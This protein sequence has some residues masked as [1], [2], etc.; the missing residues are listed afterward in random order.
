MFYDFYQ[1]PDHFSSRTSAVSVFSPEINHG[2]PWQMFGKTVG[3]SLIKYNFWGDQN[4]RHNYPP[5]PVLDPLVGTLF[6]LGLVYVIYQTVKLLG[7]RFREG[8]RDERLIRNWLLLSAFFVMLMPEFLTEEG[9]PH[10]LRAIGTQTPVFLL[11]TLPLIR[12]VDR[13]KNGFVGTRIAFLSLV[14]VVLFVSGFFNLTKYF[15]FFC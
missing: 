10:A 7:E 14:V 15:V 2:H 8:K 12:L 11:A 13:I 1:H 3:L 4:W 6:L 9:L 5:Y